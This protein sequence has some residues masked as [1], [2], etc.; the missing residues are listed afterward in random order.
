MLEA[1]VHGKLSTQQSNMEDML[2][3]AVFGAL[4]LLP[5]DRG[6]LPFLSY[7]KPWPDAQNHLEQ[8]A[9][10]L[11]LEPHDVTYSF[12]PRFDFE[13][14]HPCEPDLIIKIE[15]TNQLIL[16]EA[17][18]R[19]PKSSEANDGP[20]PYDQLAREWDNLLRE[21]SDCQPILVF[22]T[23][24]LKLPKQ[25][26]E[27]SIAE[28]QRKRPADPVPD[29]YWLSWQQLNRLEDD[30][31]ELIPKIKNILR[32]LDLNPFAG[33]KQFQFEADYQFA[34]TTK[35]YAWHS[36]EFKLGQVWEFQERGGK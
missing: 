3:S 36:S 28:F 32:R 18:L 7:A 4:R 29:I 34:T 9:G 31:Q 19:S 8:L 20:W 30:D 27:D 35:P 11:D 22:L 15:P 5:P 1:F 2:T 13:G 12:W 6:V 26:I 21:A 25:S 23:A 14:C 24:D 10:L 16:V 33:F 17:K